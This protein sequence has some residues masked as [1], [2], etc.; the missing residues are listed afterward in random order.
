M[1]PRQR[2]GIEA[3]VSRAWARSRWWN[4][5]EDAIFTAPPYEHAGRGARSPRKIVGI[6]SLWVAH[7][8]VGGIP[9]NI[10][11]RRVSSNMLDDLVSPGRRRFPPPPVASAFI[12]AAG[13]TPFVRARCPIRPMRRQVERRRRD[14]AIAG[15]AIG[16]Q[17]DF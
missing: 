8:R 15:E 1:A 16:G 12:R 10:S 3:A 5:I 14:L 17:T 4:T 11:F 13:R 9:G 6:A 7:T 2:E